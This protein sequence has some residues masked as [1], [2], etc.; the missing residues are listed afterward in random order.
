MRRQGVPSPE[1]LAELARCVAMARVQARTLG[2]PGLEL[3]LGSRVCDSSGSLRA[4]ACCI[5]MGVLGLMGH[6][7]AL[8]LFA[9]VYACLLGLLARPAELAA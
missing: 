8:R 4:A 1:S 7:S 2:N 6:H 5:I 3:G 9:Y